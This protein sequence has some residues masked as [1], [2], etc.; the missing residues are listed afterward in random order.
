MLYLQRQ[1][2][3]AV[4]IIAPNGSIITVAIDSFQH[5]GLRIGIEAP[6][7]YR[8]RQSEQ[9]QNTRAPLRLVNG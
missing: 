7:D 9:K 2:G 3:E 1:I 6:F 5:G 8:I 4:E